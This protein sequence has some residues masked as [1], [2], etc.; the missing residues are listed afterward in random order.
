M[1]NKAKIVFRADGHAK[2]GLGHVIRSLA[3]ADMLKEDFDCHFMIRNPLPALRV[4][5]M[6]VCQHLIGISG[7]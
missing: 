5:I 6:E 1:Q 7:N 2:M 4:Q 3:L